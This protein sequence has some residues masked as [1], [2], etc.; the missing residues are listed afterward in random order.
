MLQSHP[1]ALLL[2][3]SG[4]AFTRGDRGPSSI[5][6]HAQPVSVTELISDSISAASPPAVTNTWTLYWPFC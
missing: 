2:A 6:S 1:F 4:T 3:P 5:G